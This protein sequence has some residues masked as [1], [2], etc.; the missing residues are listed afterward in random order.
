MCGFGFEPGFR[1]LWL[2]LNSELENDIQYE[3]SSYRNAIYGNFDR[4]NCNMTELV[5]Y[6]SHIFWA[7]GYL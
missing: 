5:K 1:A 4:T 6:I 7:L 2:D 3:N